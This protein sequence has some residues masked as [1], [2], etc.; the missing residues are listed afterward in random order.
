M[1]VYL[2][3]HFIFVLSEHGVQLYMYTS[4]KHIPDVLWKNSLATSVR[5]A[6]ALLP[7]KLNSIGTGS[8]NVCISVKEMGEG[9]TGG[10][11]RIV[12]AKSSGENSKATGGLL[13]MMMIAFI[14]FN[15]LVPLIE[16][17]CNSNPW[18]FEFLGFRWNQTE[19]LGIISSSLWPT[20]P[21]LHV[22][23]NF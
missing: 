22:R 10:A 13:M 12:K 6:W 8:C 7:V 2:I 16:G 21:R 20:D 3:C 18:K 4:P 14:T 11:S 1:S 23:S 5:L 9:G 19:D 17:L 15:R